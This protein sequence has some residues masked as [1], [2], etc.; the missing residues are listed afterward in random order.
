MK[1]AKIALTVGILIVTYKAGKIGGWF[2]GYSYAVHKYSEYIPDEK[3]LIKFDDGSA[4][5]KFNKN[6][7]EKEASN[8]S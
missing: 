1:F 5:I 7:K 6:N 2:N 8:E 4:Y 3:L